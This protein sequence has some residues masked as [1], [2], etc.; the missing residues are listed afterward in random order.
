MPAQTHRLP[1][2]DTLVR[3]YPGMMSV[4]E[5]KIMI[6]G[7]ANDLDAPPAQQWLGGANGDTCTLRMSRTLN[8]SGEP[9]PSDFPGLATVH[10][11]DHLNYAFRVQELHRW[12]PTRFG[13]PDIIVRGAPVARDKFL[14]KKGLI[15]FD[16]TFG[17]NADGVTRALGHADLWDGK[18]FYDEILGTS[19]PQR[20]FFNIADAVSLWITEGSATLVTA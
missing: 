15:V 14:G 20:D 9:V 17:V 6:G 7:G 10:G 1:P 18:T 5:L 11:S 16:I 19:S 12:L 2:F 13:P 4:S 8:Y 3:Q